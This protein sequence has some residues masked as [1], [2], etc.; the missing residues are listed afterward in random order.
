MLICYALEVPLG[1][2]YDRHAWVMLCIYDRTKALNCS[3][4]GSRFTEM[5]LRLTFADLVAR[6][7]GP[8]DNDRFRSLTANNGMRVGMNKLF[9][10]TL[11]PPL[12]CREL[13][14]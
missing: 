13:A 2:R 4:N 7:S 12:I 14:N 3:Y 5:W 6:S 11:Y 10:L 9:T 1:N 8:A